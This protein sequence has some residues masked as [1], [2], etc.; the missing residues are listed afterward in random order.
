MSFESRYGICRDV[1]SVSELMTFPKAERDLLIFLASSRVCPVAPVFP[2]FSLPAR[3]TRK[4]WPDLTEP[5][6]MF[7]CD[8]VRTKILCEREDSAFMSR[9]L[10]RDVRDDTR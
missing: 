8:I 4:S 5:V 6:S 2:T 7:F 1:P 10:V 3:S 9:M